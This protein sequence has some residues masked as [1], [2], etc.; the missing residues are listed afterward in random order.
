M[1]VVHEST[2]EGAELKLTEVD[3]V[4]PTIPAALRITPKSYLNASQ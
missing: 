3:Q 4:T 2:I 1:K